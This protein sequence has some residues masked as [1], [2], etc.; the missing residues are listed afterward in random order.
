MNWFLRP[1]AAADI[2]AISA[3][4]GERNPVAA[5]RLIRSLRD[6]WSLLC[7]HPHSGVR[8][9]DLGAGVRHVVVGNYLTFYRVADDR[10][11]ILRVFHG[12]RRLG[13]DDIGR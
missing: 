9:D 11:D 6:R 3:Y 2:A 10:L 13:A 7:E 5:V 1:R 4:V 8:R 12:R